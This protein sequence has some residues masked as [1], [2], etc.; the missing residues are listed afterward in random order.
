MASISTIVHSQKRAIQDVNFAAA[1]EART[2]LVAVFFVN[3]TN[4]R[5]A[6]RGGPRVVDCEMM[7][8]LCWD[9]SSSSTASSTCQ[10]A[11][12]NSRSRSCNSSVIDDNDEFAMLPMILISTLRHARVSQFF[13]D[14]GSQRSKSTARIP[15]PVQ[16]SSKKSK[17]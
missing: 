4:P 11:N 5:S 10:N 1:F 9:S 15:I 6:A 12:N 16:K 2:C 8:A 13:T 17:V 14:D 7:C 3:A